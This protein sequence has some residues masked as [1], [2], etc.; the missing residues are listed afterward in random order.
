MNRPSVENGEATE[1]SE[2]MSF[3]ERSLAVSLFP[4]EQRIVDQL[5]AVPH[6]E[7]GIMTSADLSQL[8]GASRSS[9]DR[10]SRKL[11]Y[12]GLKEMRKALLIEA[13]EK[14]LGTSVSE[15][16]QTT[17]QIAERVMLAVASRAQAIGRTM[18]A[19][20]NLQLLVDRILA[21]RSICL[22]GAG[23]SAIVCGA[24]YLRLV[25]LGLPVQFMEEHHAQVTLASLMQPND[26]AIIVSFSG[27]THSTLWSARVAHEHGALVA[28]ICGVPSSSLSKMADIRIALPTASAL[29]GSAEVLDRIVATALG[30]VLFQCIA[31]QEPERLSS[32]VRI[33][34]MFAEDR[35]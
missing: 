17:A 32:S 6:Y 21:A 26:L 28:A 25:R 33:D 12:P 18:A 29:P 10:L 13:G 11:G 16:R 14:S 34:D 1:F 35:A 15:S 22:F 20:V 30:E 3:A 8:S 23:E 31:A 2:E 27:K 5:L 7:I 4:A 24:I 19:D 9:I